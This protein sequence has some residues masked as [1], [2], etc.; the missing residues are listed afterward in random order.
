MSVICSPSPAG[1]GAGAAGATPRRSGRLTSLLG[2]GAAGGGNVLF[3]KGAAECV[4]QR[5]TKVMLADGSVVPLDKE[6]RLELVRWG[7]GAG[8]RDASAEPWELQNAGWSTLLVIAPSGAS[9]TQLAPSLHPGP[10]PP[11]AQAAGWAGGARAAPAGLCP[12]GLRPG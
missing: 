7:G 1:P 4:L 11:P 3:V 10:T 8:C 2:G 5:C 9:L 6:A 12:Q